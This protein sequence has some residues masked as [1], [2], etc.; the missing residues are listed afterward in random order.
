MQCTDG[1]NDLVSCT[2]IKILKYLKT[3]KSCVELNAYVV[4][5]H[6]NRQFTALGNMQ[7]VQRNWYVNA[8]FWY[9]FPIWR[10]IIASCEN[11]KHC[12]SHYSYLY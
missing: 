9:V 3:L 7:G 8:Y 1:W 4:V 11:G 12:F 10:T 2:K 6:D 5:K